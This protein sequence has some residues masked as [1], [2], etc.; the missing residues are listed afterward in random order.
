ME[1]PLANKLKKKT[2]LEVALLQDEVVEVMYNAFAEFELVLHGGTAIW[3]CYQGNR[4]SEDLDFYAKTSE[5]FKELFTKEAD[6]RNLLVLKFKESEN[7]VFA[8]VSNEEVEVQLEIA[9]RKAVKKVIAPYEK[10]NG[11][12]IN[13]YTLPIEEL[14]VEKMNAYNSRKLIRDIYD[15]Y[16]LSELA[17]SNPTEMKKFLQHLPAPVDEKNLKTIVYSGIAPTFT[18]MVEILQA[19]V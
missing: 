13:I 19:R 5:G 6:K 11:G 16:H 14:I 9:K 7:T 8:K 12:K 1:I 18:Q 15:V 10:A 2:H 4:F 3:R 17:K